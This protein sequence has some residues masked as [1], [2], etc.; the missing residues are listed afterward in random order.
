MDQHIPE[1]ENLP[2]DVI[3]LILG[4]ADDDN[5][6]A[7]CMIN[8]NFANKICNK[9]FWLNKLQQRYR[10]SKTYID[11]IIENNTYWGFYKYLSDPRPIEVGLNYPIKVN[12]TIIDYIKNTDFGLSN[13]D[14][15]TSLPLNQSL[16]VVNNGIITRPMLTKLYK[17]SRGNKFNR[18]F[19][20]SNI[21][22]DLIDRDKILLKES[23]I[24]KL[25]NNEAQLINNLT[26]HSK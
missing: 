11:N 13:P 7:M 2:N 16:M 6:A 20:K 21:D 10:L 19:I 14:D 15:P 25:L 12:N 17:L 5:L 1:I 24:R 9:T 8:S 18:E 4:Y 3:K 22:R 23:G 26:Y